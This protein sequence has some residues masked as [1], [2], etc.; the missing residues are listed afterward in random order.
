MDGKNIGYLITMYQLQW[1][2]MNIRGCS[3]YGELTRSREEV[4]MPI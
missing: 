2:A 3:M 1:L 4:V